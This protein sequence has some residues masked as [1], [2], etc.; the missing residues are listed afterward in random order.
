[1]AA[2]NSLLPQNFSKNEKSIVIPK[3]VNNLYI[4]S[5]KEETK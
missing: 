1:M 4:N 2:G 5:L 3:D